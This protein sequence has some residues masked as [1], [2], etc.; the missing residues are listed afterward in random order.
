MIIHSESLKPR[1]VSQKHNMHPSKGVYTSLSPYIL[2]KKNN[3][4]QEL[5]DI[6]PV[7]THSGYF[8]ATMLVKLVATS[9]TSKSI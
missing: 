2:W 7:H 6:T 4:L 3:A 1:P 5:S 9:L 8:G